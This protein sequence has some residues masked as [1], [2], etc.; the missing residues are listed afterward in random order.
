MLLLLFCYLI[1]VVISVIIYYLLVLAVIVIV[2][3]LLFS[4]DGTHVAVG[5]HWNLADGKP[6]T[7][8]LAPEAFALLSLKP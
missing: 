2:V 6:P 4:R 1:I 8:Y 3:L 7:F 5:I